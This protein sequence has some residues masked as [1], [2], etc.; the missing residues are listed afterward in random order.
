MTRNQRIERSEDGFFR[1]DDLVPVF[2]AGAMIGAC[3]WLAD[4]RGWQLL[5]WAAGAVILLLQLSWLHRTRSSR[6]WKEALDSYAALEIARQQNRN[7]RP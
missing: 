1:P 7:G 5:F 4:G 3:L 6:R 2:S